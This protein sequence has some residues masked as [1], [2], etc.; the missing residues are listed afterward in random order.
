VPVDL[1]ALRVLAEG[2]AKVERELVDSFIG[3]S[4]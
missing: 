3:N 4:E 2:D 1:A